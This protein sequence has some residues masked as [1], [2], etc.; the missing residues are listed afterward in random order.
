MSET[1]GTLARLRIT[2][3]AL[4]LGS[5][6]YRLAIPGDWDFQIGQLVGVGICYYVLRKPALPQGEDK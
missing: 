2:F 6:I 5:V 1:A 3:L 4:A